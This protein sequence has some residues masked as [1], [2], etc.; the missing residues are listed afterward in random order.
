[1]NVECIISKQVF[2][3][4]N[5]RIFGCRPCDTYKNLKLNK[6]GTFTITGELSYLVEG[7][8]YT[9]N[10]KESE[11]H[12]N[13][14]TQYN[15]I[16]VP[17]FEIPDTT[18][19][20]EKDELK[21]LHEITTNTLAESIHEVYPDY[22][23]LILNDEED[24][25]DLNKIK[26]V[27]KVRHNSHIRKLNEKYK[28][29]SLQQQY[30]YL[31]LSFSDCQSLF[32]RFKTLEDIDKEIKN[33][34]YR[35]MIDFC[36]QSFPKTDTLIL[37]HD[38]SMRESNC[39]CE[40]YILYI[41][42]QNEAKG[43]TYMSAVDMAMQLDHAVIKKSKD[44]AM[45]SLNI[46]YDEKTNQ[47]ARM[48]TH[49]VEKKIAE[50]ILNKTK[51]NIPLDW[52][53]ED[54]KNN[55]T[56]EQFNVLTSFCKHDIII[57]N[58]FAGT[59]KS[60]TM[61]SLVQMIE[62][63]SFSYR[64]FAPTGKAAKRLAEATNREASTIHR[65][66]AMGSAEIYDDVIIIDECSML[67]LETM[68][69]IINSIKNSNARIVFVL[70]IEQ[71]PPIGLGCV[72]REM[73][74]SEIIPTCTLTKVFRFS[75]G[76]MIKTTTLARQGNWYLDEL[77]D[78]D[79]VILGKEK[80]YEYI[81]SNHTTEQIINK[82]LEYID[83]GISPEDIAV[84]TTRNIG[85]YGTY[86]INNLIQKEA[87]P[88]KK[89]EQHFDKSFTYKNTNYKI[90]FHENDLVLITKNNY[91]MLSYEDYDDMTFENLAK[92]DMPQS[93]IF[94]GEIGKVTGF[95]DKMMMVRID[96]KT[97]MFSQTDTRNLLL[98]YCTTTFKFQGSQIAYP[99]I[100]TLMEHKNQLNKNL[101]YTNLSRGQ[102]KITEI[103]DLDAIQYSL[104]TKEI[105]DK[106]NL[107]C[108]MVKEGY[109]E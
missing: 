19:M 80:D 82:Y 11:K 103:G 72:A 26:G 53:C 61:L 68:Y 66:T 70:D 95:M 105:N 50:F 27:K 28:Y 96:D 92:E 56:D 107:I 46:W 39:R 84:L 25:I 102:K 88:L 78:K 90:T 94:N 101:L 63:N 31:D 10:I 104:N 89:K 9:L 99:I 48:R 37:N 21:L 2:A 75:S 44:V 18:T 23:K 8:Q 4:D 12:Y 17:S 76:G 69:M 20:T 97:I 14:E 85:E 35:I 77:Q 98:G 33:N 43:H 42:Q 57:L 47:I 1:M 60:F 41:L 51:Q 7:E 83:K 58:G 36:L 32:E 73:I 86:N 45:N 59:G 16:S 30:K 54:F 22:C 108:E 109:K 64:L 29:Y 93:S 106:K 15:V 3:R 71:L 67:N 87:N 52:N 55:L 74:N 62:A 13:N 81:K 79:S 100:L 40:Y 5:F 65:G 34:P 91:N 49:V 6:Y 24:K 38:E